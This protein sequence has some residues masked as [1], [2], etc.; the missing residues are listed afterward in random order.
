MRRQRLTAS[1]ARETHSSLLKIAQYR[2]CSRHLHCWAEFYADGKGWIPVDISEAWKHPEKRDYVF[3]SHDGN[4]M[5]FSVGRDLRLNP[6]PDGTRLNYF[7]YPYVEVD[8]REFANVD[9]AFWFADAASG[10]CGEIARIGWR[11]LAAQVKARGLGRDHVMRER[12]SIA[13]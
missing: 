2:T 7:V 12:V 11:S 1:S 3:A 6:P 5:Q 10:G 13:P 4:R 9:L 8:G